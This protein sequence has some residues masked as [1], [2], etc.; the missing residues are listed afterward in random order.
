MKFIVAVDCEGV[1]CTV[2]SPG[3]SLNDSRDLEFAKLQATREADAAARGLFAAGAEQVIVWD[4]HNGSLNL[5]YEL[6][7]ERCDIALGVDFPH[8]FPGLDGSFSGVALIGYHAMDNTVDAVI[9]HTFSSASYQYMKIN[10]EEVGEMA[11]DG[12]AAGVHGVP[13]IF[14]SSDDKGV[15]E[16]LN[17]FLGVET[18]TTKQAMG[19]NAAISKHPK[20]VINE[21]YAGVQAAVGRLDT[22]RPFAFDTPMTF[23]I[24]FKRIEAAQAASRSSSGWERV[25]PYTVRRTLQSIHDY[26]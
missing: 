26:F 15:A 25:D 5:H 21:I 22:L 24:R 2:G 13:V 6:L 1:A 14:V 3:G 18:V 19:W 11:I 8:R 12:A 9:C 4:N 23:E 7:D 20:R 16:A 10:E 17:F